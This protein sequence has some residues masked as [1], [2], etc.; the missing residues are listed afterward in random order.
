MNTNLENSDLNG[1]EQ[2]NML[3]NFQKE[4]PEVSKFDMLASG[5]TGSGLIK[6]LSKGSNFFC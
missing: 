1:D 3:I 2:V 4:F 5:T 6:T